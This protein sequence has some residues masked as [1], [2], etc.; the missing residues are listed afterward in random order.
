MRLEASCEDYYLCPRPLRL[1]RRARIVA[2]VRPLLRQASQEVFFAELQ[3]A[4]VCQRGFMQNR[5]GSA[6]AA[7]LTAT[8]ELGAAAITCGLARSARSQCRCRARM[9]ERPDATNP[10][11]AVACGRGLGTSGCQLCRP[12]QG[13]PQE[14]ERSSSPAPRGRITAQRS[15]RPRQSLRRT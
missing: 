13:M 5:P 1:G 6:S 4:G 11:A 9:L 2:R 3:R 14:G 15:V 10:L 8:G 7:C 12:G